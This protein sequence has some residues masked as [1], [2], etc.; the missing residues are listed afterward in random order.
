MR[1][2]A[3]RFLCPFLALAALLALVCGCASRSTL[4]WPGHNPGK[5][6]AVVFAPAD[7][8]PIDAAYPKAST[9]F[10]FDLANRVNLLGQDAKAW[11]APELPRSG[12]PAWEKPVAGAETADWVVFTCVLSVVEGPDPFSGAQQK[13]VVE[14]RAIDKSGK[15][16]FRKLAIGTAPS[17]VSPKLMSDGSKPV[18]Q[19]AWNAAT[20]A[21]SALE[22]ALRVRQDRQVDAPYA[23]PVVVPAAVVEPVII[24]IRS[25]PD[26]ADVLIDGKFRGT[27]PLAVT[28]PTTA[29]LIQIER[30]GYHAWKRELIPAKD[31]QIEPALEAEG[32][33]VAPVPPAPAP[34]APP[35]VEPAP[36]AAPVTP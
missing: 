17:E 19:A 16:V 3:N 29:V 31:L 14:M 32:L 20:M 26:H 21:C 9:D 5:H 35:A 7:T 22:D 36:A 15:T 11:A 13:A 25:I 27:T 10:A 8:T 2:M 23:A 4:T 28:L 18:S 6:F 33:P 24:T 12:S 1:D 30:Q 34:V